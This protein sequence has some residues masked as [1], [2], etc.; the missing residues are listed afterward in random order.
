MSKYKVI[1]PFYDVN[2]HANYFVDEI[3]PREGLKAD[4]DRLEELST[5]KNGIGTS[6]IEEIKVDEPEKDKDIDVFKEEDDEV[7]EDKEEV[8]IKKGKKDSKKPK[9]K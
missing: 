6:L 4:I 3:Y 9:E 8:E 2:H 7:L 1:K 5:N